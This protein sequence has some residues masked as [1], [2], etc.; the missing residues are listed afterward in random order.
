MN[1]ESAAERHN[2]ISGEGH[3]GNDPCVFCKRKGGYRL[4]GC[5][6]TAY[7]YFVFRAVATNEWREKVIGFFHDLD[8]TWELQTWTI[9]D[10][11]Y[12]EQSHHFDFTDVTLSTQSWPRAALSPRMERIGDLARAWGLVHTPKTD[13]YFTI[14]YSLSG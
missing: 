8:N 11:R 10:D 4:R 12:A 3:E 5:K 7:Y 9:A 13:Y 2:R 1:H 14:S 6:H